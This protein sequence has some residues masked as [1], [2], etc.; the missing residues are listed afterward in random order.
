MTILIA[1]VY[2]AAVFLS[3]YNVGMWTLAVYDRG[4]A[5]VGTE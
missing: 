1:A 2:A 5:S 3:A 4:R